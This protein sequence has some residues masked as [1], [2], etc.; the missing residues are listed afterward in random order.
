MNRYRIIKEGDTWKL[1]PED[2]D[3]VTLTAPSK[4][5]ILRRTQEFMQNRTGTVKIHAENGRLLQE[6]SYPGKRDSDESQE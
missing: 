3:R 5:E 2:G 1:T 6:R 4:I